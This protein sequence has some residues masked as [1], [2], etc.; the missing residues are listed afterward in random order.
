MP[1]T[2][3]TLDQIKTQLDS[4]WVWQVAAGAPPALSISYGFPLSRDWLPKT[5]DEYA[6]WSGFNAVQVSA[7]RHAIGLWDDLIAATFTEKL[8]VA[9]LDADIRFS[10]STVP[11]YAYAYFPGLSANDEDATEKLS[12]SLWF[13]PTYGDL[14]TPI[15]GDYG[16]MTLLHEIGHTI[17]L[18]HPGPY[19][20]EGVTYAANAVYVEDTRQYTIMSYFE[21]SL[22]GADWRGYYPQTP[23]LHDV[24]AIQAIYGADKTTRTGDTV[25]GFN[26]TAGDSVYDFTQTKNPS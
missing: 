20:G 2:V 21:S 3:F 23:M 11:G 8:G 1:V 22:T 10:N 9:A 7:A 24:Y 6:S 14:K 15:V 12:G 19:D 26:A 5:A 13:N 25:Y 4:G 18:S 17:G 16:F